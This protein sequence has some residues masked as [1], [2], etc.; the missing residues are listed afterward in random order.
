MKAISDADYLKA[1]RVVAAIKSLIRLRDSSA[2]SGATGL[3]SRIYQT[4][5]P[6]YDYILE[7]SYAVINRL[8]IHC[9]HFTSDIY[10]PYILGEPS[11]DF[12]RRYRE[13]CDGIP[14][15][16]ILK[17]P[18][19]LGE[20]GYRIDGHLVNVDLL[21]YQRVIRDLW[22]H[23]IL[24]HLRSLDK[25]NVIEI[26]AGWGALA[27]YLT[28][29]IPSP[30]CTY[31]IVDLPEILL[32]SGIYLSIARPEAKIFLFDGTNEDS[33]SGN[34]DLDYVLVPN[35]AL[36][37]LNYF[38][39]NLAINTASFQEM[40]EAQVTTYADFLADHLDGP[41]Y[42]HNMDKHP[43]NDQLASVSEIL[44]K[45]FVLEQVVD[46]ETTSRH[47]SPSPFAKEGFDKIIV[48]SLH[49]LKIL[50]RYF[51]RGMNILKLLME[52][53]PAI[54]TNYD[55]FEGYKTIL[56]RRK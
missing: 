44:S 39:F 20:F 24:D 6:W 56:V 10:N 18:E 12:S 1:K 14:E 23:G 53:K 25:A 4:A 22:K 51:K 17:P 7:G 3:P 33:L 32:M 19:I 34:P 54:A 21:R 46:V 49:R 15:H 13:V 36:E 42:S 8:R 47:T 52:N 41:L 27:Y 43:S 9:Y 37:L 45:R 16:L 30:Q 28:S 29:V 5:L 40:T 35:F 31:F 50:F 48:S 26:G 2:E 38:R 11:A 55:G